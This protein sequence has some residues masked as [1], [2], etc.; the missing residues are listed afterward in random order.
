M[1]ETTKITVRAYGKC[2]PAT[3]DKTGYVTVV[4]SCPGSKNGRLA[5][6]AIKV[7]DGHEKVNCRK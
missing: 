2:H 5:S 4:C 6:A 1:N 3:T 7:A